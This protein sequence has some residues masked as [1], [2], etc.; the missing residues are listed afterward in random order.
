MYLSDHY[1][2]ILAKES[3]EAE[4]HFGGTL[5]PV[6]SRHG[7]RGPEDPALAYTVRVCTYIVQASLIARLEHRLSSGMD[8][9]W[10]LC[11]S[12]FCPFPLCQT[13]EESPLLDMHRTAS[14]E[15]IKSACDL[16]DP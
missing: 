11:S 2:N 12:S 3:V 1:N 15:L 6:D 16:Y 8:S 13:S 9:R 4:Q 7:D 14:T 5:Y 10:H